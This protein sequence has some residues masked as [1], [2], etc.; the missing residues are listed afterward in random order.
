MGG[1]GYEK[2]QA[3]SARAEDEVVDPKPVSIGDPYGMRQ[4]PVLRFAP[5]DE[6]VELDPTLAAAGVRPGCEPGAPPSVL[7]HLSAQRQLI[8]AIG[9]LE[10]DIAG[11]AAGGI[12]SLQQDVAARRADGAV[13]QEITVERTEHHPD[14]SSGD[15]EAGPLY[16]GTE[17]R[18]VTGPLHPEGDSARIEAES[19]DSNRRPDRSEV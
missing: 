3:P 19:L 9:S 6:G 16:L 7:V 1:T 2:C 4:R 14:A 11:R 5:G 8:A 10:A 13:R 12:Q 17:S 18:P 15:R